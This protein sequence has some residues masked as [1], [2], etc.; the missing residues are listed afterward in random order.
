MKVFGWELTLKGISKDAINFY[1]LQSHPLQNI[2]D[3]LVVENQQRE[4][5]K[6]MSSKSMLA[7]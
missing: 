2:L 7:T 3:Y 4:I 5:E 6:M 1:E